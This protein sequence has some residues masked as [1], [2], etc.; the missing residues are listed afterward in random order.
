MPRESAPRHPG[1]AVR[2][3]LEAYHL[4]QS[5]AARRMGI[6]VTRLHDVIRGRR[7]ITLDTAMLLAR[8]FPKTTPYHWLGLQ[9]EYDVYHHP[10]QRRA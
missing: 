5:Q 4:N 2:T 1:L 10:M 8:L 9:N 6:P 7:G 3:M